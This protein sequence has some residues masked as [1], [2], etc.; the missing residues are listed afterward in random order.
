[1]RTPTR[2]IRV[3]VSALFITGVIT[4]AVAIQSTPVSGQVS[5]GEWPVYGG[6]PGHTRF[7]PLEQIDASNVGDLEIAWRWAAWNY[8]PQPELRNATTPLM[9]DG[10]LYATAGMRRAVVAKM[11]ATSPKRNRKVSRKWTPFSKMSKRG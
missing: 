5:S 6:D 7:S 10:V 9:V 1:M 8:G 2:S 4:G 11:E 3:A